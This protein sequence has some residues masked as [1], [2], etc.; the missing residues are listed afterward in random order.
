M[1]VFHKD[2]GT[3]ASLV[4]LPDILPEFLTSLGCPMAVPRCQWLFPLAIW[5]C[6]THHRIDNIA[7]QVCYSIIWFPRFL[8]R[9]KALTR[10]CRI[11]SYRTILV[12]LLDDAGYDSRWMKKR[13][14][15]FAKWRRGTLLVMLDYLGSTFG[16]SSR[17]LGTSDFSEGE[18]SHYGD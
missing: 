6:G 12:G 18:A 5:C 13:P 17:S 16:S 4:D 7:E 11:T 8:V 14:P 15:S 2:Y 1:N 9:L 3:E 10:F